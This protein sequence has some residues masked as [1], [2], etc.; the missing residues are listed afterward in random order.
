M[1]VAAITSATLAITVQSASAAGVPTIG[2]LVATAPSGTELSVCAL[3]LK[4]PVCQGIPGKVIS[5]TKSLPADSA[6]AVRIAQSLG[7]AGGS[8]SF[9]YCHGSPVTGTSAIGKKCIFVSELV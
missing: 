2:Q 1:A 9:A 4:P 7:L 6:T 8:A 3:A 5:A